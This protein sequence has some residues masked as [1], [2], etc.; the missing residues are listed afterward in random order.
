MALQE[1]GLNLN[2]AQKELQP[3]GTVAFPC[4]GYASRHTTTPE[5]IIPWHWHE[6]L[7]I[8]QITEGVMNLRIPRKTFQVEAGDI[9]ILNGNILH[10]GEGM[11][12]CVLR[13]FVFSPLLLTGS[14]SSAFAEKYIQPLMSCAS[15]TC[16][17]L[18]QDQEVGKLFTEAFLSLSQE[19]FGYEFNVRDRLSHVMLRLYQQMEPE[20]EEKKQ[21]RT[22]DSL[23]VERMMAFIHDHYSES[24]SLSEISA[25]GQIGERECLR[26][27]KRSIGESPIQYLLKYRL[28]QS[29]HLLL[30][31]SQMSLSDISAACG[32][33]APSYFTKQFK[34]F[35][36]CT[37]REYRK[38]ISSEL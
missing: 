4:A 31:D 37:P 10:Y 19:S 7:E 8:I 26:C 20:M 6:E 30:T 35:Y 9:A 14:A 34:R 23:R 2:H 22:M 33:D 3:H 21:F 38:K 12:A 5:S 16:A 27:F 28:M 25:A 1:C 29:A 13:S 15:F 36:Q 24:I 18:R 32:F 11:P 17:I